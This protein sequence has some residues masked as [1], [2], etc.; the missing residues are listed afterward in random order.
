MTIIAPINNRIAEE[1]SRAIQN[2]I[3]ERSKH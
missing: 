1:R 3:Y 2:S